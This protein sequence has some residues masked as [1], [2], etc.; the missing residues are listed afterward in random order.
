MVSKGRTEEDVGVFGPTVRSFFEF[1]SIERAR[2]RMFDVKRSEFQQS[3]VERRTPRSTIEPSS[4]PCKLEKGRGRRRGSLDGPDDKLLPGG[5]MFRLYQ[6]KP[7]MSIRT[8][9]PRPRS[10]SCKAQSPGSSCA[11]G[12]E[13][14]RG[15]MGREVAGEL[16]ERSGGD[17]L[18]W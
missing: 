9:R 11:S 12:S 15:R 3:T 5:D 8:L 1:R 14:G 13:T 10:C 4:S 16:N 7:Q 2:S 17:R 6:P 18:T